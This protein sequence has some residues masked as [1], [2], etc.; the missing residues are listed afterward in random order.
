MLVRMGSVVIWGL[1]WILHKFIKEMRCKQRERKRNTLIKSVTSWTEPCK[2]CP[3]IMSILDFSTRKAVSDNDVRL[4]YPSHLKSAVYFR[5]HFSDLRWASNYRVKRW[6]NIFVKW[7]HTLS[8]WAHS[9]VCE[10]MMLLKLWEW[11]KLTSSHNFP[12]VTVSCL[13]LHTNLKNT[14]PQ[15]YPYLTLKCGAMLWC[16]VGSMHIISTRH[17]TW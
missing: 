7:R 1:S 3:S 12:L 10:M 13:G 11:G 8:W 15:K 6:A 17:T 4:Q 14:F 16:Y 2:L 9:C 5:L